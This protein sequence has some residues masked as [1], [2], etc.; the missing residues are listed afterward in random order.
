MRR[1][2]LPGDYLSH[3]FFFT[4]SQ[5]YGAAVAS[6][7]GHLDVGEYFNAVA[8]GVVEVAGHAS[9]MAHRLPGNLIRSMIAEPLPMVV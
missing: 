5:V 6:S 8:F 1:V 7:I 4:L 2:G 3:Q 9:A